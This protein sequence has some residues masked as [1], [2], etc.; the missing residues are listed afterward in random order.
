M[1]NNNTAQSVG[2]N[3][4]VPFNSKEQFTGAG[5]LGYTLFGRVVPVVVDLILSNDITKKII[6]QADEKRLHRCFFYDEVKMS[7]CCRTVL[8]FNISHYIKCYLP[9]T[10][11]T[12]GRTT[13]PYTMNYC[14][15]CDVGVTDDC[16]KVIANTQFREWYN[17]TRVWRADKFIQNCEHQNSLSYPLQT[18][19]VSIEYNQ[20]G[21]EIETIVGTTKCNVCGGH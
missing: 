20:N 3:N 18:E 5:V 1:L 4:L 19:E 21:A 2:S 17:G 15:K 11:G 6:L 12:N 9:G 8:K 7:A 14:E 13:T 10:L 16:G